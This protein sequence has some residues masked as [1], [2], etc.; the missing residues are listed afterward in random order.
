MANQ[1]IF[2]RCRVCGAEKFV[3]KRL[4]AAFHTVRKEDWQAEWDEWFEEHEWG[5]CRNVSEQREVPTGLDIFELSY[6]HVDKD[7]NPSGA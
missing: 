5:F 1:R 2:I 4:I 3:A 6:E 7:G